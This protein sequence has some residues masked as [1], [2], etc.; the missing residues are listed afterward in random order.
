MQ[1][2]EIMSKIQRTYDQS[3][4][5]RLKHKISNE[6]MNYKKEGENIRAIRAFGQLKTE[7]P[8]PFALNNN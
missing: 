1:R 7:Q 8:N 3:N 6:T 4:V 5:I 2:S